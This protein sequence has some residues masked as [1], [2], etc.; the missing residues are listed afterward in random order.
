MFKIAQ[1]CWWGSVSQGTPG[2]ACLKILSPLLSRAALIAAC[3]QEEELK[4]KKH[5][6]T[7]LFAAGKLKPAHCFLSQNVETEK[8]H[9]KMIWSM[10]SACSNTLCVS[11][12]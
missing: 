7:Q 5:T 1:T 12:F 10:P 4:K 2:K 8:Y 3:S 11:T 6:H 9:Q